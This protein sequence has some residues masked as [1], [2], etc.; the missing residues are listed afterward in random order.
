MSQSIHSILRSEV[1]N[2]DDCAYSWDSNI[3]GTSQFT[4]QLC[5]HHL[6]YPDDKPTDMSYHYRDEETE[7]QK[8]HPTCPKS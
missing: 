3:Y 4:K 5:I 7:I 8:G 1:A 2:V 6:I